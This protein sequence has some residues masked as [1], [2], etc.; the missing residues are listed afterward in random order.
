MKCRD[1]CYCQL[2][3]ILDSS[4]FPYIQHVK[5]KR[6]ILE[7]VS[8]KGARLLLHS[9]HLVYCSGVSSAQNCL[10]PL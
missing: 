3:L 5:L 4:A 7:E 6:T 2:N 10:L 9:H 8:C 1:R